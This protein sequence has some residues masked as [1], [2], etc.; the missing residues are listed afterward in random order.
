MS[1]WRQERREDD[2]AREL[3]THLDLEA[4]EQRRSGV[5]SED[6]RYTALRA[7]GN[8][9][10]I[11]EDTRMMWQLVSLEKLGQDLRYAGR[12]ARKSPFF[13][14]LAILTLALGIGANTA[15]FSVVDTVLLRPLLTATQRGWCEWKRGT[16]RCRSTT[17]RP[18]I[19]TSW[20]GKL[21]ARSKI[22][23]S[24]LLATH[25]CALGRVQSGCRRPQLRL[26]FFRP[27]GFGRCWGDCRCPKKTN[28]AQVP[29]PC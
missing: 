29:L 2:L 14:T 16:T 24:I 3:R 6:A 22:A 12:M 7:F 4:E 19:R 25:W 18:L 10:A 28:L 23:V 20:I 11:E 27:W 5:A 13:T 9:I 26:P 8:R 21:R 15:I 17:G 1:W